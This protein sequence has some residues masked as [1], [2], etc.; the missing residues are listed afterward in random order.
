[1]LICTY[2]EHTCTNI[3]YKEKFTPSLRHWDQQFWLKKTDLKSF[4]TLQAYTL[5]KY[6]AVIECICIMIMS[7]SYITLYHIIYVVDISL[8]WSVSDLYMIISGDLDHEM[9]SSLSFTIQSFT[10]TQSN[11]QGR[12]TLPIL[13]RLINGGC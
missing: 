1:M 4:A 5:Q 9:I 12:P 7:F 2:I 10:P 3:M 6:G 11:R 13:R 8:L